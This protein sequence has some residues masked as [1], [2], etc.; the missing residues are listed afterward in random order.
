MEK[1]GEEAA[2]KFINALIK[3]V[4]TLCHGYLDFQTGIEIIGHINLSVDKENSLDYILKEKVCKNAENSTLFISHS[5]HAEPKSE[6]EV[7]VKNAQAGNQNVQSRQPTDSGESGRVSSA[8]SSIS[9]ALSGSRE[10]SR[11]SN[12]KDSGS[13]HSYQSTAKRKASDDSGSE[14]RPSKVSSHHDSISHTSSDSAFP[15]TSSSPVDSKQSLR[16]LRTSDDNMSQTML[17]QTANFTSDNAADIGVNLA[18]S[19]L[20]PVDDQSNPDLPERDDESDGDL[21]VT[22]IKEEYMEGE[23]S[24]CEF[25]NSGQ[26]FVGGPHRRASE[27][28]P[29][30]SLY[31]V[32]LHGSSA[33]ATYVPSAHDQQFQPGSLGPSTS[34]PQPGPSGM[35]G[36]VCQQQAAQPLPPGARP[37]CGYVHPAD[38]QK[39][40]MYELVPG[41]GVFI[42]QENY[43]TVM[44]KQRDGQ[45]DGKAMAR[46]LMSCFWKQ[47]ELVGASIAEPPRPHH[48]SLDKGIINAIL[49][50]CAGHSQDSEGLVR[51][52]LRNKISSAT[53]RAPLPIAT[54]R[55][56]SGTIGPNLAPLPLVL[57]QT[58]GDVVSDRSVDSRCYASSEFGH[59]ATQNW[60]EVAEI[61]PW[62]QEIGG[63]FYHT[64]V[65]QNDH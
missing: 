10:R 33:S 31:P 44:S 65:D 12:T 11:Q 30:P 60:S 14:V 15:P 5:F 49:V 54:R 24:A 48:R 63:A 32:A 53:C 21:E 43:R 17:P 41:S 18:G 39:W 2:A 57:P 36:N 9:S 28:M 45:P 13:P 27:G 22:F 8:L 47:S 25:E 58:Q 26:Q 64:Q 34:Q 16:H 20:E 62:A 51:A 46:Y 23:R 59:R 61:P 56:M 19:V 4:Q 29:D 52:A 37:G 7:P 50:F 55:L 6:Q 42:H 1:M 3:S 35:R 38:A 40:M